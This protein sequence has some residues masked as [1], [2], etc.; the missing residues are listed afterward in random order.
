M[1]RKHKRSST[2]FVE[3]DLPIVPM[4]DMSFQL[5]AFFLITFRPMPTEGQ[6]ALALPNKE[7]GPA[8]LISD[9]L[10]DEKAKDVTVT[11]YAGADGRIRKIEMTDASGTKSLGADLKP[12]QEALKTA[13]AAFLKDEKKNIEVVHQICDLLNELR[14][15][16]G[17]DYRSLITFVTDR[18]GHD[19]RYAID[20]SKIGSELGWEPR[21]T[22]STGLRQTVQ[23]Y[24]DN[25][26]WVAM[27]CARQEKQD[28]FL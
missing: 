15:V 16:A 26:D 4:L 20:C 14:P 8:S 9:P 27:I 28:Q 18:P 7:G 5:M 11:V 19:R 17:H 6:I 13:V 25:D 22:F 12:Y 3:P 1:S 23:W 21:E 10:E 2:D 24:L